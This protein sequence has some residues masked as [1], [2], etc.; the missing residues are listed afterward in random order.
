MLRVLRSISGVANFRKCIFFASFEIHTSRKMLCFTAIGSSWQFWGYFCFVSRKFAMIQILPCLSGEKDGFVQ[1]GRRKYLF[2]N[3]FAKHAERLYNFQART[4][5][6]WICTH[7]RSGT[8][9]TQEMVWLLV[10]N[11]DYERGQRVNLE[12]RSPFFE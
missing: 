12:R 7:P 11:F 8:T 4:S 10:N 9:L 2:P 5:D 6:V 1:V 3:V